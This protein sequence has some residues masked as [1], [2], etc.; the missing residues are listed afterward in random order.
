MKNINVK[1]AGIDLGYDSVKLVTDKMKRINQKPLVFPSLAKEK[2]SSLVD[3]KDLGLGQGFSKDRMLIEVRD[4]ND[5]FY[6]M[7]GEYILNQ[8]ESG[9]ANYE[10]DKY[11]TTGELAKFLAGFTELYPEADKIVIDQLVTGLPVQAHRNHKEAMKKRFEGKF[12]ARIYNN[13]GEKVN[14]VYEIKNVTVIP[15]AAGALIYQ[16]NQKGDIDFENDVI[17]FLDVGGRTTDGMVYNRG[18]IIDDS[19]FSVETGMSNVFRD[20]GTELNIDPNLIREKIIEG[21]DTITHNQN[22]K[23]IRELVDKYSHSA[24]RDIAQATRNQWRDFISLVNKIYV[25]GGG[26]SK[27]ESYL[28][29]DFGKIDVEVIQKPQIAN[30]LGYI[31]RA[32]TI[33]QE[34]EQE[35]MEGQDNE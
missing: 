9:G 28:K 20:V 6:Y 24:S 25:V 27:L 11:Q 13:E 4:N 30:V 31:L 15:Q 1:Y 10:V 29:E 19:P 33:W 12:E 7:V 32:E 8:F 23:S 34:M 16:M 14:K 3:E 35:K 5:W 18:E 2:T 21:E 22:D 26:A 17:P